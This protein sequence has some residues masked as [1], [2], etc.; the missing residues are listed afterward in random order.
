MNVMK[1]MKNS[2]P[3]W[4]GYNMDELAYRKVLTFARIEMTKE[5]ISMDVDHIKKGNIF[6]SGS[7]FS[8]IMKMVDYTDIF[9][10]GF[11]LWRK[12]GPFFSRK[13]K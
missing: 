6:L 7:W 11:T 3:Q 5:R 12:I 4:K 13:K 10:I 1:E 9:M 8:K 2:K